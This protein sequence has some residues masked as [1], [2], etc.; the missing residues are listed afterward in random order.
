MQ[1]NRRR[2]TK[3]ELMLRKAL[4]EAGIRGYRLDWKKAPGRPDIA[5]P[6]KKVAVFV[7]GCFWHRCPRCGLSAPR[8]NQ[9]YWTAKF[10]RNVARDERHRYDLGEG[11]WTVL[12]FYECQLR[13]DLDACVRE[14]AECLRPSEISEEGQDSCHKTGKSCTND[15]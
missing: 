9:E 7:H 14:V 6:G 4:R 11:G 3:P 8:S 13:E 5:F 2:D 1:G 12:T 15:I 10:A